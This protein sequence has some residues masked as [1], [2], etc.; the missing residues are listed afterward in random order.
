MV[1]PSF[2]EQVWRILDDKAR[3][4]VS[5]GEVRLREPRVMDVVLAEVPTGVRVINMR[6]IGS[7]SGIRD[8]A[9]KRICDYL[10]IRRTERGDEAVFVELKKDLADPRG[11]E[12]LR[13]SP[14]YLDYIRSLCRIEYG[15]VSSPKRVQQRYVLIG[16]RTSP[17]LAKQG[18]AAG[19]VLPSEVH[20][21][22]AIQR[23]VGSRIR[24]AWL[25]GV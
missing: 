20:G 22:I 17:G 3:V 23:Y 21:E 16:K 14:P 18:V 13:R 6:R 12:Q 9:W 24:F 11:R 5:N 1:S 19:H 2:P 4:P 7:L 10:L 15:A 25:D 8:G